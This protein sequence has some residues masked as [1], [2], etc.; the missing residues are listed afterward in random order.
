MTKHTKLNYQSIGDCYYD[1]YCQPELTTKDDL[2]KDMI[3]ILNGELTAKDFKEEIKQWNRERKEQAI[4]ESV[5]YTDI[6]EA[7]GKQQATSNDKAQA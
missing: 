3:K 1:I 4:Q 6:E 2:L 5:P 7:S